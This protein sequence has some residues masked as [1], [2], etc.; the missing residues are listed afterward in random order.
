MILVS[1]GDTR[2]EFELTKFTLPEIAGIHRR[3]LPRHRGP[4][5]SREFHQ[6]VRFG[7]EGQFPGVSWFHL[8]SST[9]SSGSDTRAKVDERSLMA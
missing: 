9:S 6:G 1:C 7:Y 5:R 4:S 2:G 8:V 3:V